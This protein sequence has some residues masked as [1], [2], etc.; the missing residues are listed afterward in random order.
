MR[1]SAHPEEEE[2]E[3]SSLGTRHA[4]GEAVPNLDGLPDR[5]LFV[6]LAAQHEANQIPN[7][8]IKF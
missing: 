7:I 1:D 5:L 8:H 6:G 4:P 2:P 3:Q